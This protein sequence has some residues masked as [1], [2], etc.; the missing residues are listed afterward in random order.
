MKIDN[1]GAGRV[2][3]GDIVAV[4]YKSGEKELV[5]LTQVDYHRA[6]RYDGVRI[7]R[8]VSFN[9]H[10]H[11]QDAACMLTPAMWIHSSF[12][13]ETKAHKHE[14]S[15]FYAD[16]ILYLL[17]KSGGP[18]SRL[19]HVSSVGMLNMWFLEDKDEE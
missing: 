11:A 5:M 2:S 18:V 13:D 10:Y 6:N 3:I 9:L 12:V 16:D 14:T 4:E 19:E 8:L 7:V 1:A 17:G 15:V